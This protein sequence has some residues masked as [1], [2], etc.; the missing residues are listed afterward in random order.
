MGSLQVWDIRHSA[1]TVLYYLVLLMCCGYIPKSRIAVSESVHMFSLTCG[2][3]QFF[4]SVCSGEFKQGGGR[5]R[6]S[7]LEQA[8]SEGYRD[9]PVGQS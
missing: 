9:T 7:I 1:M 2:A 5:L 8:E 4:Q 6:Q 3:K